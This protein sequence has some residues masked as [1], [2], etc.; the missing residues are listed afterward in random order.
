MLSLKL[1]EIVGCILNLSISDACKYLSPEEIV[2]IFVLCHFLLLQAFNMIFEAMVCSLE[3]NFV[4][5]IF[6]LCHVIK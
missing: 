4:Q 1:V 2:L 5:F 6:Y 3:L